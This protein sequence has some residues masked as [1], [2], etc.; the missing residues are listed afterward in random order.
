MD[1]PPSRMKTEQSQISSKNMEYLGRWMFLQIQLWQQQLIAQ[2]K[3]E[4]VTSQSFFW[5]I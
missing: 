4:I 2:N 5:F 3:K 1:S